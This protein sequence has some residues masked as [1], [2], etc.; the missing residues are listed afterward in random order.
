MVVISPALSSRPAETQTK[1]L[2]YGGAVAASSSISRKPPVR[3][4]QMIQPP[5]IVSTI[6]TSQ[7][8][9]LGPTPL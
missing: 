1:P 3:A 4:S 5:Q 9:K 8:R 2:Q 7:G 6:D